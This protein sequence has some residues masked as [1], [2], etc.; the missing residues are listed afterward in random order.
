MVTTS[1]SDKSPTKIIGGVTFNLSD[2]CQGNGVDPSSA[3]CCWNAQ[4]VYYCGSSNDTCSQY[5]NSNSCKFITN[6]CIESD[7][8]SGICMT[9]NDTFECANGFQQVESEVCLN[10]VCTSS[11]DPSVAASCFM[12]NGTAASQAAAGSKNVGDLSLGITYLEMGK[13]AA[14]DALNC[15]SSPGSPPDPTTCHI[16]KGSFYTWGS[17]RYAVKSNELIFSYS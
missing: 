8:A 2:V 1:C 7:P 16:F 12:P 11:N 9:Y 3:Q 4:S 5:Q 17:L 10:A 13:Q 14:N 6:N 15:T